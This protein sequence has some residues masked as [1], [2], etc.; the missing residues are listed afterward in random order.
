MDTFHTVLNKIK[1]GQRRFTV[2]DAVVFSGCAIDDVR[3]AL[4]SM[5]ERYACRL[6]LTENGDLIYDFGKR[7]HRRDAKTFKEIWNAIL[8][9]VWKFFT[10][11][12]KI[13]LT[14]TLIVYFVIFVIILIALLIASQSSKRG[15]H[16]RGPQLGQLV[17]IFSS[18]FRW[19]THSG[20]ILQ[21]KDSHGYPYHKYKPP[22]SVL[23]PH[24]KNLIASVYDF[25]FGPSRFEPDPHLDQREIAAFLK[26]NK[27]IIVRTEIEALTGKTS[28]DAEHFFTD[29]LIRFDGNVHVNE[30]G[31]IF[32]RFDNLLRGIDEIKLENVI[33]YWDEYEPEYEV[34][35]N[36]GSRNSFIF[37]M[38][39]VNLFIS[40]LILSGSLY[41]ASSLSELAP[42]ISLVLDQKLLFGW[43]P[44]I[45]SSF[46]FIIPVIRW[47]RIRRLSKKRHTNNIRKR[48]F[49]VI[50]QNP[51]Y[52][53][54]IDYMRRSVNGTGS[55][56]DLSTEL[57]KKIMDQIIL[58]QDGEMIVTEKASIEYTFPQLKLESTETE[59]IR[60]SSR[61]DT[62][63]GRVI[64]EAD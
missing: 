52:S 28:F 30:N 26:E 58:E 47:L 59:R 57:I 60:L 22:E 15:G 5:I 6:Q 23:K 25:V 21:E 35:G 38:N 10:I 12:F 7:L 54:S 62:S 8:K 29:C 14:V 34:T 61:P 37:F 55:E 18:I 43:I 27:G 39:G 49:K 64:M 19:K 53:Y 11:L 1:K 51:V 16:R 48:I 17:Y 50:Y 13:W 33:Y 2:N 40:Y 42:F 36:S 4:D 44:F 31:V 63:L 41:S 24:K 20:A 3:D 9:T 46:F 32:G 56:E 45:F